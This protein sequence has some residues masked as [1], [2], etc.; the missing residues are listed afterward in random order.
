MCQR[1]ILSTDRSYEFGQRE[2]GNFADLE[3]QVHS[4]LPYERAA[5]VMPKGNM[6]SDIYISNSITLSDP[7]NGH[8]NDDIIRHRIR[9]IVCWTS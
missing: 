5:V 3:E 7:L 1:P 2:L 4:T 8:G 9:G 6:V